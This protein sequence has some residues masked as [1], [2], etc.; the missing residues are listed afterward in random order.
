M[1]VRAAR[2]GHAPNCSATGLVVGAAL[3]TVAGAGA[4]IN[5]FADRLAAYAERPPP[6]APPRLRRDGDGGVL[7]W[8]LPPALV[9]LD[10][11]GAERAL[12]AGAALHGPDHAPAVAAPLEAHL[13]LGTRCPVRCSTCHVSA[14]PGGDPGPDDLPAVLAD[15]AAAGVFEVAFGGGEVLE[16]PDLAEL[17][18][19]AR[20]LGLVPNL[21]TSGLGLD[22]A[23]ARELAAVFGQ[24]NVSV[25]GLGDT[26]RR[27][28][29]YDGARHALRALELLR[30]AGARTGANTVL[31]GVVVPELDALADA[32]AERGVTEWQWLRLKP[33]GRAAAGWD[34]ARPD[35][36][37][38]RSLWPTAL[39]IE[40]RTGLTL[41]WDCA[42]VPFLAAHGVPPEA[43][44]LTGAEG[45]PGGRSL[46]VRTAGG[47]WSPC[48]FAPDGDRA[49][50]AAAWGDDPQLAAWRHR[51]PPPEC[52]AC[53]WLAVC[54][55]GCRVVAAHVTG[56]PLA[57]DP[58]CP[59]VV[60]LRGAA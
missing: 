10:P 46:V 41:R 34:A 27:V 22:A 7:A 58:E 26:F 29:G 36:A 35:A 51:P 2:R 33:A 1:Q 3:L 53:P 24:I 49:P 44:R 40:A 31:A 28:R 5:A 47:A 19:V 23:R 37:A 59:R 15:L 60:A 50:F 25:D 4:L 9:W 20:G 56:D 21:T 52:A 38:L 48:S 18:R 57:A 45:C 42:M 55:S 11:A 6:G 54:G 12:A 43:L 32:L 14:G 13:S 17:G 30:D 39:A 8:A 16:R